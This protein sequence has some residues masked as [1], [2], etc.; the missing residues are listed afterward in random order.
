[1]RKEDPVYEKLVDYGILTEY[2]QRIYA[3][4]RN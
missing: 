2:N 4:M 3:T 1:M